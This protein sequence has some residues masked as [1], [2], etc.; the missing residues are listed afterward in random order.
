MLRRIARERKKHT[1][2]I[3]ASSTDFENSK[4]RT[5]EILEIVV[6]LYLEES[7]SMELKHILH[8]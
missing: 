6:A 1:V 7:H 2:I 5:A 8:Q 3:S 4:W